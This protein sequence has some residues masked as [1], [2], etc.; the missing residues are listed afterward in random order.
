VSVSPVVEVSSGRLR[1]LAGRRAQAFLGIPFAQ[2]PIDELRFRP[3]VAPA[4]WG[5]VRPATS[6]GAAAPQIVMAAGSFLRPLIGA[7][8]EG[9]SQDCLT[10]NVWTPAADAAKRPVLVWIHGGAFVLGTGA[11]G[12]YHGASTAQRGDVVV[13]T[14]NYRLGVLGFLN[15]PE[16]RERGLAPNLGVL[17]QIRALEWVRENIE[18]FGGDPDNV[19]V[20]G[21][22]AGGMS[23]GTLLATP[24]AEGLFHR[25]ILQSGALHHVASE[26]HA[27]RVAEY[28][29]DALGLTPE[30][31]EAVRH[32]RVSEL[33][34]AQQQAALRAGFG[35]GS[36]PWSPSVDDDLLPRT[37]V[38]ALAKGAVA[39]VPVLV[40]S[41]RDEW[42]LFTLFDPRTRRLDAAGLRGRLARM[43]G[44]EDAAQAALDLYAETGRA[45][46][47]RPLRVWEA[48]QGDR[49][50]HHP[51]QRAADALSAA[52]LPTWRYLFSWRPP[53][54]GERVGA[55]HGLELPFVF[56]SIRSL[57]WLRR[58]LG[59]SPGARQLSRAM[60]DAWI[61]F[62][63]DGT[64]QCVALP[65]WPAYLAEDRLVLDLKPGPRVLRA[66]FAAE[67]EFWRPRLG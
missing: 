38:E 32:A 43:L 11:S 9:Q 47:R 45:D 33:V 36:L 41:N 15:H 31:A 22:S 51:A 25:A 64:P 52:G 54:L 61:H 29:L 17:D 56:G 24:R 8:A 26:A 65:E 5:G 55:C 7:S 3:P 2:P 44:D 66:P 50:F 60:Q 63:R 58:S 42:R 37:G 57:P 49:V 21:E 6:F 12:L 19:T 20:F 40:G 13:V 16:L 59:L 62:A 18:A 67:S 34:R 46:A 28:L 35:E 53:L 39:R 10:L 14:L 27:A 23:V 48:I 30:D 1:G 4:P